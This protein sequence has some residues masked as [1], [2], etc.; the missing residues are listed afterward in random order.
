MEGRIKSNELHDS[1]LH[2]HK[3]STMQSILWVLHRE[4]VRSSLLSA[5]G[6]EA[7]LISDFAT[8]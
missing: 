6:V 5:V 1:F 3:Y 7:L 4:A 2:H 8:Y